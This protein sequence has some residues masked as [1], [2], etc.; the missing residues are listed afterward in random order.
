MDFKAQEVISQLD[1][2]PNFR[3]VSLQQISDLTG[4]IYDLV[5]ANYKIFPIR[6]QRYG[7]QTKL[8]WEDFQHLID[9][10]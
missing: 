7:I 9:I 8:R 4:E 10:I 6:Q 1:D 5:A 2:L 3:Q